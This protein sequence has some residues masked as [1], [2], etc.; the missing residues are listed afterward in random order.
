MTRSKSGHLTMSTPLNPS[1][2]ARQTNSASSSTTIGLDADGWY[3]LATRLPSSNF[4]ARS[5]HSEVS[6]LVIHNISLPAGQFG[7]SAIPDLFLNQLDYSMHP[8]LESLRGIRV[9]SHFLIRRDGSLLQ[10]VSTAARAWHAGV[11]Q[12]N[13]ESGCNDF[14]VGIE[15]EGTDTKEFEAGQYQTLASL[16]YALCQKLPIRHIGGHQDIA[17]GRKT[18]PGPYFDWKQYKKLLD[19]EF[20]LV[21]T[22]A[23][24]SFPFML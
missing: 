1:S 3:S 19:Q 12:F 10:F 14:S 17:P 4:D 2:S 23:A 15:L 9:S 11:S 8:S 18:D 6:L 24:P 22:H 5:E 20:R 21:L 7:G 13:G 16:S